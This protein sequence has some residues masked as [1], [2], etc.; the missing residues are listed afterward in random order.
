MDNVYKVFVYGTLKRGFP[1][2]AK[3]MGDARFVGEAVTVERWPLYVAGRRR[4][5]YLLD[6]SGEGFAVNGELFEVDAAGLARVDILE[7]VGQP[8]GYFRRQIKVAASGQCLQAWVYLVSK[9]PEPVVEG[10]LAC[11][12]LDGGYV[13]RGERGV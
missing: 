4:V 9:V 12:A 13:G 2:F 1:N 6:N 10:P 5:P 7:S 8:G 11:Y 3:W